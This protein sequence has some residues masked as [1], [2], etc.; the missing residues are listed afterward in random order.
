MEINRLKGDLHQHKRRVGILV[1]RLATAKK[2]TDPSICFG[3]KKLF[4]AQYHLKENGYVRHAEWREVWRS[5]R[6]A[7]FMIEG[8]KSYESGNQFARL[9]CRDDGLFDLELRLPEAL[10]HLAEEM[11]KVGGS[12]IHV[13]R[14]SGLRFH[15]QADELAAA[16]TRGIPVS[17][18][19]HRDE[20]GWRIMPT[21]KAEIP[22]TK[23]DYSCGLIGVD[24]NAGFVSVARADRHGNVIETFDIPMVTY[25]KTQAQS[26][27]TVKKVAAQIIEF[28]VKHRCLPIVSEKLE[29]AR[30][31]RS[32][33][34][35]GDARY[36]R[37]LSSFVYG[38]FDAAL[39]ATAARRGVSH[40]RVNPTYTSI[41][42]RV[43]FARRYGLS[44]HQS[45]ALAIAR[46]AMQLGEQPPRSSWKPGPSAFP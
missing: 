23:E 37:M 21:F 46:R 25:G 5:A 26:D 19:F 34:D 9:S 10:K 29:F 4:R 12:L 41:I 18:R 15:H 32:L 1:A 20:T 3:T 40:A 36:A 43:K 11:I 17:V 30:K 44:T 27:D 39:S 7:T 35:A 8:A 28:S 45:A 16:I 6:T 42:G 14:L 33:R 38:R 24:L 13:V 22:E 2:I 31:K